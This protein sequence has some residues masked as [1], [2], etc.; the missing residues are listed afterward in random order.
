[1]T[2]LCPLRVC[3]GEAAPAAGARAGGGNVRRFDNGFILEDLGMGQPD[4]KPA[5]AGAKV[6]GPF[7][8]KTP[9]HPGGPGHGGSP[10][11]SPP[12]PAPRSGGPCQV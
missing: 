2:L 5:K 9:L 1:M 6:G 11:A 4:G 8:L 3:P 7:T 10:R 12:R